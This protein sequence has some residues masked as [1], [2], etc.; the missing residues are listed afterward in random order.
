M[1]VWVVFFFCVA[2]NGLKSRSESWRGSPSAQPSDWTPS[3]AGKGFWRQ[4]KTKK[5]KK[6]KAKQR[7]RKGMGEIFSNQTFCSVCSC[8]ILICLSLS[9]SLSKFDFCFSSLCVCVFW[10]ALRFGKSK[11]KR[12]ISIE[13]EFANH[14]HH[15]RAEPCFFFFF[16]PSI[17]SFLI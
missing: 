6:Q 11:Y 12:L 17:P 7:K 13:N 3:L 9:I 15:H 5:G 4:I 10:C 16:H 14:R 1:C 2:M 8:T